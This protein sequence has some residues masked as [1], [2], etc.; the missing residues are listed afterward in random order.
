[1]KASHWF[2]A[3]CM[4]LAFLNLLLTGSYT[5]DARIASPFSSLVGGQASISQ[6]S[7]SAPSANPG[8]PSQVVKLIFIH[9]STGENWLADDNGGLGMA[10]MN[11]NYFV[12]DTNY[13]WGTACPGCGGCDSAYIGSCTDIGHWW[14]WFRG[15]NSASYMSALYVESGQ[16]AA[17]SRLDTDP[18]GPNEIIMFKSCFPNSGLQGSPG[19]SIPQIGSNPLRGQDAGSEHHT[20]ANA[21]GIYIDLLNYFQTR[22][23]KL[24]VVIA[25][26]PLSDATYAANA[27]VFNNWLVND[28]LT[29]YPLNNVAVFGFYNV[30]TTNGGDPDTNDLN[31]ETGNHHRWWNGVIQYKTDGDNDSNPNVLEYPTGDDHPSQAGNL[32]ATGEFVSLL[33]I[34]Y[35]RWKGNQTT[36]TATSVATSTPTATRTPTSMPTSTSTPTRTPTGMPTTTPTPT[37]TN[38]STPGVTS[39][40]SPTRTPTATP[41][42]HT[43]TPTVTPTQGSPTWYVRPDGGS[44][45]QCTGRVNAPY[46]GA[47]SNQPCAWDHPFRALPPGGTPRIAGGDTLIIGTGSYMMGYGAPG[48]DNCSSDYPWGCHMPPIPSGPDPAPPTRILGAGWNTGSPSPPEL[49]GTERADFI[50]DLTGSSNVEIAR[51]EI[52]DH[53]SCVEFHAGSLICQRDTYPYGPWAVTGLYAE[54]SANVYLRDLNIHGLAASGVHAGRLTDWTVENARIAGNGWVGWD[55]DIDGDDSNSGTLIFRRWTV[56]WNGCGETHPGGQPTGCWAQTAGGYGDGVGTGA[57]GGNWIIEDSKF[58]HNTSDGLD[59]LYHSLGGSIILNRV[60]A[61]GNAGNQIKVTGQTT[62]TNNVLVGNCAFFDGKS[63]TYNVDPC[64]ALG[65]TL[66]VVY[67]G[68]EQVSITNSTF[69]GQGDG[70]VGAGPREGYQCNGSETLTGRNNIFLGDVDYFDPQDLTFLFYYENCPGLD[71]DSDYSLRCNVKNS[72]YVPGPHDLQ[73]NP[74]LVGP[75]LGETYGMRLT[76]GSPAINAGTTGGAP[77]IDFDS[78]PRSSPPD[79]GAYEWHKAEDMDGDGD[80]DTGDV[81]AVAGCWNRLDC[82]RYFDLDGDGDTDIIDVMRVAA[83]WG[84]GALRRDQPRARQ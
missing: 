7:L 27:R 65:N 75:L 18:G 58:L 45:E 36:P 39:T 37:R 14:Q 11:S 49:W 6:H 22:P 76:A 41:T 51:L 16:N 9:H 47:G 12:S 26:P 25:A 30:L 46:P 84:A 23:D 78:Y 31:Q 48:A 21:K 70:L 20:V 57:T 66:V 62:I 59:L 4:V 54:D 77:L 42:S 24:F 40:N 82:P 8:P 67:T 61:E 33:N 74:Q 43:P 81:Q 5:G 55:G 71:F 35:N 79:I 2:V 32:K 53:S 73:A 52:T 17:Y 63:F 64:R 1:M 13:G 38:S 68:G 44:T 50:V 34:F 19:D 29:G 83:Q 3:G 56:E 60:H 28:W 15:P 10:L 80:I 72:L 69:Y